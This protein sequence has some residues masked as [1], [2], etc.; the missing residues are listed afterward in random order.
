MWY[1]VR[2]TDR[3]IGEQVLPDRR[4]INEA[5]AHHGTTKHATMARNRHTSKS[6]SVHSKQKP[7]KLREWIRRVAG[8][9]RSIMSA[10]QPKLLRPTR[11]FYP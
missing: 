5:G 8:M 2:P 11:T 9:T 10:L 3:T 6:I 4:Q 7:T 1:K